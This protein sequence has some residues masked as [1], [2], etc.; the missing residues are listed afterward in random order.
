[1][2]RTIDAK[3]LMALLDGP[4]E[5]AL[6]DVREQ[7]DYGASHPI[8]AANIPLGRIELVVGE[9]IPRLSTP[10]VVED[11]GEGT[12][13][14]QAAD[15]LTALGY[16]DIRILDGGT[17]AWGEAGF[18][19]FSGMFVP[20]KAFGEF[21]EHEY[22]TPSVS[23]DE[24]K[25]MMDA[26]E[27]GG[28]KLVVVDSRPMDEYNVMNIPTGIDVPGAEL[29]Y[30]VSELAP[31]PDTTVVVNCAGRTRSIIGA[32]SLINAG[33]PNKVVALRNGTMG[34]HLAGY[35][36]EHGQTA[37]G[38][39]P[40]PETLEQA[41]ARAR[42]VAHRFGVPSVDAE[43]LDRWRGER[44]S[45]TLYVLDVRTAEE[46]EASRI[47]DSW[48]APGGQLVQATD[49]YVPVR[50]ARIVLVDDRMVRAQ[51]TASWLVQLGWTDVHV[52]ESGLAGQKTAS[53][54]YQ[55]PVR[56]L[57]A[58]GP[59]REVSP[60][61]AKAQMDAG[62]ATLLDLAKA[63]DYRDEHPEG[64]WWASRVAIAE[65]LSKI[66]EGHA[67]LLTSPDG[68]LARLTANDLASC[69]RTVAVVDGGTKAW[70]ASGLP[71]ASG[72]TAVLS[73]PNDS[74]LRPYDRK[75][76][77]EIEKAMN[78]YLTWE[79]ALVEQIKKAGGIRFKSYA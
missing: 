61:E 38:P 21:V 68:V 78:D 75:N 23:A 30:R 22:G 19:L 46:F 71:L 9:R 67:V 66:P 49:F 15:K 26:M 54:P 29:V 60:A 69:G 65:N 27:A 51:M 8:L 41:R 55:V 11:A 40:K 50:N 32:Q 59:V 57:E 52:L 16:T 73:P 18:E 10:I 70:V 72:I 35:K 74:Y 20:S 47:A 43:T 28:D 77:A 48:H 34:W 56:G 39:D 37:F 4:D 33:L 6:I 63:L 2:T 42:D 64:A 53:G 79:V 13:A 76:K 17:K 45:R 25:A 31:D 24:L 44:D 12:L 62:S 7:A 3:N 58:L 14:A 5:V 36:L 1:M